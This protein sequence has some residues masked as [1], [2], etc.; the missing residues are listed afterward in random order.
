[1]ELRQLAHFVAV[2]E[3]GSFTKAAARLHIVQSGVSSS[4]KL[5]EQELGA[6]LLDR[7]SKRVEL[8]DAGLAFLPRARATLDA[9]QHALDVVQQ[10][11]SGLR[12]TL[13]IG[14]MISVP[15]LDMPALLGDFH[16]RH[17]DV[18][19]RLT[20]SPSTGSRG[21][22]EAVA[23]G[24]LHLAFV[25]LPGQ[26]PAGVHLRKLAVAQMDLVGPADHRL[27]SRP[28]VTLHD[29]EGEHFVD[30]PAGYGNRTVAD[31]AFAAAGI[32]R[33]VV[34]EIT[35]IATGAAFVAE[36][37]GIALLPRFIIPARADVRTLRISGADLSWPLSVAT[38]TE[39]RLPAAATAF[40][41][42]LDRASVPSREEIASS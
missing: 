14:T 1:M 33:H 21:L 19:L 13:R 29:L 17:P 38:S 20:G 6:Q 7:T 12:G 22:V 28:T 2:A 27:A 26:V 35:D 25:A 37:L 4:I 10:V 36:G 31:T 5:L 3:E 42:L 9:A 39:R 15:L 30:F 16:R 11:Q 34:I 8:T 23:A 41:D 18:D 32:N 24:S 40:L